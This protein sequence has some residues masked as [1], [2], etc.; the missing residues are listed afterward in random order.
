MEE[1]QSSATFLYSSVTFEALRH[2]S[3]L[4]LQF[5]VFRF[6]TNGRLYHDSIS[7]RFYFPRLFEN[8]TCDSVMFSPDDV[9]PVYRSIDL[10]MHT[11]CSEQVGASDFVEFGEKDWGKRIIDQTRIN[12]GNKVETMNGGSAKVVVEE[13]VVPLLPYIYEKQWSFVVKD[14]IEPC[15]LLLKL[16]TILDDEVAEA[17][18]A[19]IQS[20]DYETHANLFMIRSIFYSIR[21]SVTLQ[22]QIF[23]D[24]STRLFV[25][26]VQRRQGDCFL[27][28][29][30]FDYILDSLQ[31]QS[32]FW[33]ERV[34]PSPQFSFA[35]HPEGKMARASLSPTN[36]MHSL[37]SSTA[38]TASPTTLNFD[39]VTLDSLLQSCESPFFDLR[40]ESLKYE[41]ESFRM[42]R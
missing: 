42:L 24:K 21:D 40:A 29:D 1:E 15:S 8:L 33:V 26:E 6:F 7:L 16:E 12:D 9:T 37:E 36:L 34:T 22:I 10:G 32:S 31:S 19:K 23:H 30:A 3:F 38:K 28:R 11:V 25:V 4:C 27:F 14:D 13:K 20:I 39:P 18:K 17:S 2:F 41:N 5:F 35:I